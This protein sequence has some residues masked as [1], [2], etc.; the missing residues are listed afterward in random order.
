MSIEELRGRDLGR[1]S[2][3]YDERDAILY[4]IAVGARPDELSLVY[5]R[6]LRVLPTFALTLGLWAVEVAGSLG[7]YDPTSSLHVS[8]TLRVHRRLPR[9][10]DVDMS[11]TVTNVWDRGNA[12]V[13][14]VE[15]TSEWFDATYAIYLKGLGGFGGEQPPRDVQED[16]DAPTVGSF[17]TTPEQAILYRLTGDRHPI[18]IDPDV[19]ADGGFER[20]ILHGLCTLGIATLET[21]RLLGRDPTTVAA[22]RARFAAPVLPGDTLTVVAGGTSAGAAFS[23]AVGDTPVLKGGHVEWA[24]RG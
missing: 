15:T 14:D 13:L 12:A 18:H 22:L 24:D 7:V 17:A 4:A 5:E 9:S 3:G 19:A 20:P 10:G 2:I 11:A 6:D 8:Q 21:S 23:A 1:R 16:S